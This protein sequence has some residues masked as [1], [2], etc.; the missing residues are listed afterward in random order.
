MTPSSS[1]V[2]SDPF[3]FAPHLTQDSDLLRQL[4]FLPGLKEVLMTRQVHALEHATV[5]VLSEMRQS[6]A[7]SDREAIADGI[8][9]MS[10][11][12]GFY[13]YGE[14]APTALS[15]AV[16][17]ALDRL[18]NGEW[19]L[20][21]HPRCGTNLSVGM[22]VTMGLAMGMHV[23]LPKD[24]ISQILGVGIAA[25]AATQ[26]TPDLGTLAQRHLTTAIPFNL[27]IDEIRSDRDYLNHPA[28]FIQVRWIE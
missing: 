28:H 11:E 17:R 14:V 8:G 2:N 10:T 26:I 13:L 18:V 15:Q 6:L 12:R 24:P 20:A 1:S 25:T 16:N 3:E 4:S 5:W 21:L 7:A 22:L 23:I 27:A 19:D 9:G